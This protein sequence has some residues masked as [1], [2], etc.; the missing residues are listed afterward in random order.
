MALGSAACGVAVR[1]L[2]RSSVRNM[3]HGDCRAPVVAVGTVADPSI[4]VASRIAVVRRTAEVPHTAVDR[5]R[6]AALNW[7]SILWLDDLR[8]R[9]RRSIK[10]VLIPGILGVDTSNSTIRNWIAVSL[11]LVERRGR[12]I[13]I[14]A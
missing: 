11:T 13:P 8:A 1:R 3:P 5:G 7:L 2:S 12:S 14:K 6:P 10:W 4:A 9:R